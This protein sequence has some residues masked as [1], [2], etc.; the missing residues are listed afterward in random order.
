MKTLLNVIV[1]LKYTVFRYSASLIKNKENFKLKDRQK[2]HNITP[3]KR[4]Y[5]TEENGLSRHRL[6]ALPA[7]FL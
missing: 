2:T 7:D 4:K 1:N 6:N 5:S 3:E